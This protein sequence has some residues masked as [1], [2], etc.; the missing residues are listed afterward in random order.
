MALLDRVR[1]RIE[2]DLSDGELTRLT[3]EA[4]QEIVDRWG[5]N[6]DPLDPIT[7]TVEVTPRQRFVDLFRPIDT[8][9]L[10]V[11]TETMGG[12]WWTPPPPA[13][14]GSTDYIVHNDGRTLERVSGGTHPSYYWGRRIS[15]TYTPQ[16][17]G[18]QRQEVAIKLVMLALQFDATMSN[19]IGDYRKTNMDYVATREQLI[20]SLQPRKGL[21]FR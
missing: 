2:S 10:V 11:V 12:W 8:D 4:L 3:E 7:V 19:G 17:D 15:V 5:P 18:N 14:L 16:N 6:S 20:R 9:E 21:L 13:T 1:E